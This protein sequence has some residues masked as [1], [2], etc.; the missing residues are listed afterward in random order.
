MIV[1]KSWK[2]RLSSR[3]ALSLFFMNALLTIL[4][5]H[6]CFGLLFPGT[7]LKWHPH[8]QFV[9]R[10]VA[11]WISYG[12]EITIFFGNHRAR[13]LVHWWGSIGLVVALGSI[14]GVQLRHR[15]LFKTGKCLMN[16]MRSKPSLGIAFSGVCCWAFRCFADSGFLVRWPVWW[17]PWLPHPAQ[18]PVMSLSLAGGLYTTHI[19]ICR[20]YI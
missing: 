20:Q 4:F 17:N 18:L 15:A 14:L 12:H 3:P 5:C 8:L 6:R 10:H 1:P 9:K 7:Y 16:R 2:P 13:F 19:Y 11:F